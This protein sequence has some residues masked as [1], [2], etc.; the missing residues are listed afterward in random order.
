MN[1]RLSAL[2]AL[3]LGLPFLA[4]AEKPNILFILANDL[5]WSDTTLC[6]HTSLYATPNLER[7]AARGM[8]FDR[9]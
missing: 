4:S 3:L 9:A 7:L 1:S 2:L 6:G 5:G 8:T